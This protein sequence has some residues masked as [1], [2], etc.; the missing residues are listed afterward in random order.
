[1]NNNND[2][3]INLLDC[4]ILDNKCGIIADYKNGMSLN[5]TTN[6]ITISSGAA[7]IK[8][9]FVRSEELIL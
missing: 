5:N 2:E 9:R 6:Q 8:G 1:M 7:C 4:V 3:V